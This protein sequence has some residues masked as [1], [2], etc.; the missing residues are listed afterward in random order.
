MSVALWNFT[1]G[2]KRLLSISMY[3]HMALQSYEILQY[4]KRYGNT[5]CKN[6]Y[7]TSTH[8]RRVQT[9]SSLFSGIPRDILP[10]VNI[11]TWQQYP[12]L[13]GWKRRMDHSRCCSWHR[14]TQVPHWW[15]LMQSTIVSCACHIPVSRPHQK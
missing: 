14:E 8:T 15:V 6:S 11:R 12:R 4:H 3:I 2:R 1:C 7:R 13:A 5:P 10:A 9:L